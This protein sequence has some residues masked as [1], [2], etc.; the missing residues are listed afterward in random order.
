MELKLEG[1]NRTLIS[2]QAFRRR[3]GL[4][5][6]FGVAYFE[7]KDW[8]GLGS[9]EGAGAP[10]AMIK[11]RIIEAIEPELTLPG[12]IAEVDRLT[13]LFQHELARVNDRIGLRQVEL[14]FAVSGF[15]DILQ[16]A[17]Y[18]LTQLFYT[19][20]RDLKRA[21]AELD[22]L[23]V[24]QDWLNDWA[25][26]SGTKYRYEHA[27]VQFG[28]W[29]IYDAYGRV[30]LKVEVSGAE[31]VYYIQDPSLG[32]PAANYMQDLCGATTQALCRALTAN[33]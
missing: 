33:R 16:A 31:A 20:R 18:E 5:A 30:G 2:I 28:V 11:Q 23:A 24:Y 29:V 21:C 12:L 27:G 17:A 6:S 7:P 4:P 1:Q 25:R 13:T 10:L 15:R 22:F 9:I 26:V 14:D 32:C 19:H 8:E 3:W